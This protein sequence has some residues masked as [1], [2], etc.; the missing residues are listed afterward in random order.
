M[1]AIALIHADLDRAPLGGPSRLATD[2]RGEPVI[3]RAVRRALRARRIDKT[4][5]FSSPGHAAPLRDLLSGL[6]VEVEITHAP[7]PPYAP[8]VAACRAWGLDGWRGGV[9]GLCAFDE[10]AHVPLATALA[11]RESAD[12]VC[13]IPAHAPLIAPDLVD[14]LIARYE[15]CALTSR[16][17]FTIAPPGLAPVVLSTSILADLAPTG[18]MPGSMLIYRPDQPAPDLT[19]RETCYRGAAVI[20][21]VGGRLLA[22]TSRSL[23]R[24]ERLIDALPDHATAETIAIALRDDAARFH[25]DEPPT[26]IEIELTTDDPLAATTRLRPR[27][28]L[29][30]PRRGPIARD[31]IR[32]IAETVSRADD[33]R[34][35]L[36][37]F[38]DP[39]CHPEL[40]DIVRILREAGA[41]AV[42]IRTTGLVGDEALDKA[43]FDI[44]VDVLSVTLDAATPETYRSVHGIDAYER[45]TARLSMWEQWRTQRNAVRP[46]IVPE[47]MK[48]TDTLADMEAFFDAWMRQTGWAVITGHS[49][50]ARQLDDQ[51]VMPMAP[52]RRVPC[53]RLSSRMMILAD[54][55]VTACDQDFAAKMPLGSVASQSLDAIWTGDAITALRAAHAETTFDAHPLCARCDEWHRP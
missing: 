3:R 23:R 24:V 20:A 22:D 18:Q 42:A 53:R 33:I 45:V 11:T 46:L 31:H 34:V 35:V 29:L 44:P 16:L 19:G 50:R 51:S 5:V 52:P 43:L 54:G 30:G 1:K 48:S 28:H 10:D 32:R 41:L 8:L 40:P 9:C 47:L 26:E 7:P 36:G 27:G 15:Q 13:L 37:G 6:D 17:T 38:G 2:L 39:M 21:D 25:A 4:F 12:A 14:A 55:T 49:H